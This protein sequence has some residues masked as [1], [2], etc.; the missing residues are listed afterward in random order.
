VAD[1]GGAVQEDEVGA[2]TG[3]VVAEGESGLAGADD[4]DVEQFA[5][6]GRVGGG[7]GDLLTRGVKADG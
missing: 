6:S 4:D 5:V 3:E 7:H 2:A 1:L